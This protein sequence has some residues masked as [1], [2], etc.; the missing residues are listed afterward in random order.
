MGDLD[1]V[2]Y[3]VKTILKEW[4]ISTTLLASPSPS[5]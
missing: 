2:A 3:H 1:V 4:E 5:R